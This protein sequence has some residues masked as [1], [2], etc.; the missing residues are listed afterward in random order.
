MVRRKCFGKV[1]LQLAPLF[2]GPVGEVI[3]IARTGG[4][5][6]RETNGDF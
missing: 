6:F 1:Y 5:F 4:Q 3:R 2:F